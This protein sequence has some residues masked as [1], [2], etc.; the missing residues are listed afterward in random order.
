MS[1]LEITH[2]SSVTEDQ[3]DHLGHMNVQYYGTN[4]R[5]A[6]RAMEAALVNLLSPGDEIIAVEG[7]KFGERWG[8]IAEAYG[9]PG[10]TVTDEDDLEDALR[11]ALLSDGPA[12]VDV[13][14]S[15]TAKVFPM[16]PQGKG[17]DAMMVGSEQTAT[18]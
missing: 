8:K 2:R 15:E 9:I 12:L 1:A 14:V 11:S 5:A 18:T 6:T 4:A 7:G 17:P 3:I 10:T 13:H 16:V